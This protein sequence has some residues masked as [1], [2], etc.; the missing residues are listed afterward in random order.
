ML[1]RPLN[2]QAPYVGASAFAHKAGLHVERHRPGQGRLRAR[3]PRAGRQR[4]PVRRQRDG[5]AGDDPDEGRRARPA[6]GRSG[7][8]PGDRRPQAPRARGLPLRGGRRLARAADAPG[9]RMGAGRSSGSRACASSPTSCANGTFTTEATVKV[10]VGDERY[11]CTGRGQRPGQRHRHRAARRASSAPTRQLARVH[12]TDY[13]VRI[14]DGASATGA[15][16]RVLLD[17]DR[18]RARL[19]HDRRQRQHHRGVVAGARGEPRLRPAARADPD[20]VS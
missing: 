8:Q 5:R 19:D 15:V 17:G 2:P 9:R 3:R 7:G 13:K 20:T 1:N 12:L 14:L 4:H 6:D 16:T 18:R 10:W 11:V